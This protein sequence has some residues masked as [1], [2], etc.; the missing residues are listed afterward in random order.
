MAS[1]TQ[2]QLNYITQLSGALPQKRLTK[3]QASQMIERLK[4][5][6]FQR[7]CRAYERADADLQCSG[8][9]L[10]IAEG[11][12]TL[13]KQGGA[14]HC[15]PCPRCGGHDRFYIN[16]LDNLFKCGHAA[17]GNGCGWGG[18][19]AQ[20]AAYAWNCS[21]WDAIDTLSGQSL[22]DDRPVR[23]RQ[24]IRQ[25]IKPSEARRNEQSDTTKNKLHEIFV[26]TIRQMEGAV[27]SEAREYLLRRGI[28]QQTW[29]LNQVGAGFLYDGRAVVCFPHFLSGEL[30]GI[31]RRI[32]GAFGNGKTRFVKGGNWGLFMLKPIEG[33][34]T[35]I[36]VEGEINS[37]SIWQTVRAKGLLVDVIS[38]GSEG[39]F[40]KLASPLSELAQNYSTLLV[41]ADEFKIAQQAQYHTLWVHDY[42][43]PIQSPRE[44]DANDLLKAGILETFLT[45]LLVALDKVNIPPNPP[46]SSQPQLTESLA[47]NATLKPVLL[48]KAELDEEE[49]IV[50]AAMLAERCHSSQ[51]EEFYLS[52]ENAVINRNLAQAYLNLQ[53]FRHFVEEEERL[54]AWDEFSQQSI[55]H[56]QSQNALYL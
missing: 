53:K 36:I 17:G 15:G 21:T 40:K 13:K 18:G 16:R 42:I 49:L 50:K 28:Q 33:A 11:V 43:L 41:W 52:V 5:E 34:Q 27:G 38:V 31:N 44:L 9:I 37:L 10:S 32:V 20:L 12:T 24:V 54:S 39:A 48:P 26:R 8:D 55:P 7:L 14:W 56:S 22:R 35:L 51:R 45:R 23:L 19:I 3:R 1:A 29:E 30:V 47:P 2:S 4:E 6:Q 46:A 25:V